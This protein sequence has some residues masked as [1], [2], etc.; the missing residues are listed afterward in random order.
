MFVLPKIDV[1]QKP[2]EHQGS[3]GMASA[4]SK[5]AGP[6]THRSKIKIQSADAEFSPSGARDWH[7]LYAII[8]SVLFVFASPIT[9]LPFDLFPRGPRGDPAM[10]SSAPADTSIAAQGYVPRR[11][12][13]DC[14][15]LALARHRRE[16]TGSGSDSGSG[17]RSPSTRPLETPTTSPNASPVRR[18][19]SGNRVRRERSLSIQAGGRAGFNSFFSPPPPPRQRRRF[20][21][22]SS[23][24]TQETACASGDDGPNQPS[25]PPSSSSLPPSPASL[26]LEGVPLPPRPPLDVS[27][28][29]PERRSRSEGSNLGLPPTSK[30]PA[31]AEVAEVGEVPTMPMR[32]LFI[33]TE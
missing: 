14:L 11:Q 3:T 29:R 31:L 13:V 6:S 8:A 21:S 19:S 16:H 4:T 12:S 26:F 9:L 10:N 7:V 2:Y 17:A 25:P 32:S 20:V 23:S 18:H 27:S 30:S 24:S 5:P 33:G 1:K 15:S 28:C 22:V